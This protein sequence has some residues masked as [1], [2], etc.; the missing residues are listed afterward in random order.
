MGPGA[1]SAGH[2]KAS[3]WVHFHEMACFIA[4]LHPLPRAE[5][6]CGSLRVSGL[7]AT[8]IT[9]IFMGYTHELKDNS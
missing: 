5:K 6:G 1:R 3:V 7:P 4:R 2:D 8:Q 9:Y